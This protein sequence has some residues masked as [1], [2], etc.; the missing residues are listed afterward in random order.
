MF[1][2]NDIEEIILSMAVIVME[3]R[4]LR[5]R[6]KELEECVKEY[7]KMIYDAARYSEEANKEF[8]KMILEGALDVTN[9]KD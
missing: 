6:N 4:M 5:K 2:R 8:L 1:D 7:H 3:N 9:I